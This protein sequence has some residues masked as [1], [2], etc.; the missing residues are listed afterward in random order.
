MSTFTITTPD[1]SA[2]LATFRVPISPW[3]DVP[4]TFS[5]SGTTARAQSTLSLKK[6]S[7]G[8]LRTGCNYAFN[9]NGETFAWVFASGTEII[10][11]DANARVLAKF[12]HTPSWFQSGGVLAIGEHGKGREKG[13]E[14]DQQR[15]QPQLQDWEHVVVVTLFAFLRRER[16]WRY[17]I[18][19]LVFPIK[20][21]GL[22]KKEPAK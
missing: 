5:P 2:P 11:R 14:D 22:H 12:F 1:S 9:R 8:Q 7:W 15:Q 18:A 13:I 10:L 16:E 17:T 21:G 6:T 4:I 19:G 3:A 20:R